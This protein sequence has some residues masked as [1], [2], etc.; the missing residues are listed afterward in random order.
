MYED[1]IDEVV[2]KMELKVGLKYEVEQAATFS[3]LSYYSFI[4]GREKK[5]KKER[6]DTNRGETSK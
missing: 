5:R 3:F 4:C 1:C 6:K 2:K